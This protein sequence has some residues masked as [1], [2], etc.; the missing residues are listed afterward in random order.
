MAC[1]P[2]QSERIGELAGGRLAAGAVAELLGHVEQ[3]PACS[4]E[5]DLVADLLHAPAVSAARRRPVRAWVLGAVALAAA[6]VLLFLTL[7]GRGPERRVRDLAQLAL[8]PVAGL[9][10]RG[11][12]GGAAEADLA[13]ALGDF[14][15]G[16]YRL[17]A[18]RLELLGE[19]RPQEARVHF[20]L[21]LS[22]LG[23]AEH[24]AALTALARAAGLGTSLLAEQA[25]WYQ[26]QVH[27]ALEQGSE[28]RDLLERLVELD[29]D[30]EPNAR[31]LLAE[32]RPLLE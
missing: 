23:L 17:A 7:R 26:A 31:A 28:A 21:G 1:T 15:D 22:R 19:S 20:Y 6:A 3:C 14:G 32:L 16:R 13:L 25:L 8:P 27:L 18:E 30:Y 11:E 10:L 29:G 24:E 9:V 2:A 4:Q 5:L 12:E